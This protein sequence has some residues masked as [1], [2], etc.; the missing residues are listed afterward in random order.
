MDASS[1]KSGLATF[2]LVSCSAVV[3]H[4]SATGRTTLSHSP[5]TLNINTFVPIFDWVTGG[6]G[7]VHDPPLL[8]KAGLDAGKRPRPCLV[9]AVVLRGFTYTDRMPSSKWGH[10]EWLDAFR[11]LD[12]HMQRGRGIQVNVTDV[13]ER[14]TSGALLVD[15]TS[16][17]ITY[18]KHQGEQASTIG[19]EHII[20]L[21]N[22][23]TPPPYSRSA[24]HRDLFMGNLLR[25]HF[26]G[27]VSDLPHLQYDVS[28]YCS[29]IPLELA[30][31]GEARELLRSKMA[32]EP[33]SAQA[34]IINM[35]RNS[36]DWTQDD[37]SQICSVF[38]AYPDVGMPCETC[39]LAGTKMC[40]ACRGAWY[41]S[42]GH[43]RSDWPAHRPCSAQQGNVKGSNSAGSI[44]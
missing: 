3:I 26:G 29:A 37:E 18:L 41:C 30:E 27:E 39:P 33:A 38:A 20:R 16:A 23:S 14:V 12:S 11:R 36:R 40:T 13:A 10:E 2:N 44:N 34:A 19:G 21:E 22:P 8:W 1:P 15:K 32:R 35:C 6:T 43:Q 42:A 7:F 24:Q 31:E 4:C 5:R 28:H 17:R 9:E 25:E